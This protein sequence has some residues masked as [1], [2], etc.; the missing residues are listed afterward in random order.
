MRM[1]A[2]ILLGILVL[3]PLRRPFF[4]YATFTIP[5]T[6]GAIFGWEIGRFIA[7]RALLMPPMSFLLALSMASGMG[8]G[9]GQATK[10]WADKLFT[11]KGR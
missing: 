6:F 5:A 8:F 10:E 2:Y 3:G 9:A 7:A 11:R 1:L 4:R